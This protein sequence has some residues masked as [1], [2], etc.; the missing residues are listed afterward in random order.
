[1]YIIS[2]L[3]AAILG[4]LYE[5]HHYAYRLEQ[6]IEK[7]GMR[8]WADIGFSSIYYVLKRLEEKNL[9]E[10]RVR[11]SESK[12]SRKVY[13][14]TME[15]KK[16][17]EAKVKNLLSENKKQISPFDLGLAN[18]EI[19]GKKESINCLKD[20]VKSTEKRINFLEKSI[21]M[22]EKINSPLNVIGMFSRPLAILKAEKIWIKEFIDQI[23]NYNP[24]EINNFN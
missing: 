3:E 6:I 4:L 7:R 20:Y 11:V 2:D 23:N 9:V 8:K 16:A 10:C 17:M 5:H 24:G 18:M 22:H 14:I 15:G 1:M 21:E 13:Y 12:P 19:L